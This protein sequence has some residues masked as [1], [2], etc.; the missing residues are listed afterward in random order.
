ML[1]TPFTSIPA[2]DDKL[3]RR[4]FL[5][6]LQVA[7]GYNPI[8]QN[9]RGL[10]IQLRSRTLRDGQAGG[11][12]GDAGV[13]LEFIPLEFQPLNN[14]QERTLAVGPIQSAVKE[15][16]EASIHISFV[17]VPTCNVMGR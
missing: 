8:H 16:V 4:R 3:R 17:E 2:S 12:S 11:G 13:S 1:V 15:R 6:H 7:V 5:S 10:D 9:E 14:V